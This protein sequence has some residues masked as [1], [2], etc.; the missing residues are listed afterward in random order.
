MVEGSWRGDNSP[1]AE[2]C[3]IF[4]VPKHLLGTTESANYSTAVAHEEYYKSQFGAA[5]RPVEEKQK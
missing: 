1:A 2:I 3:R 4:Q 5:A